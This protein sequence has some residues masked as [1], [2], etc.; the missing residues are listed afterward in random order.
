MKTV[1]EF[2]KEAEKLSDE[3]K[4]HLATVLCINGNDPA[5]TMT[6]IVSTSSIACATIADAMDVRTSV[7]VDQFTKSLKEVKTEEMEKVA[8][9]LFNKQRVQ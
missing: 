7:V 4:A 5:T 1:N 3:D 6:A 8:K 9:M 2:I